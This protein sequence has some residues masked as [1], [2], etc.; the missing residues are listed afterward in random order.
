L[1]QAPGLKATK[2]ERR[3]ESARERAK[4]EKD[5]EEG[6]SGGPTIF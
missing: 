3:Q 4:A 2:Y 1:D 5:G 6:T